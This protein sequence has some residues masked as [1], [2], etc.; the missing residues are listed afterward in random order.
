MVETET[1]RTI[2]DFI[3]FAEC[4]GK[5]NVVCFQNIASFIINNTWYS[6]KRASI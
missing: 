6:D 1:E 5:H 2:G 3:Y 4:H